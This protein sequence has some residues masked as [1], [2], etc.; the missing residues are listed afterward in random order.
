[1]LTANEAL[2]ILEEN[3][4][5][6]VSVELS[7]IERKIRNAVKDEQYEVLIDTEY[8]TPVRRRKVLLT[9]GD[10]GYRKYHTSG[11]RWIIG[12]Y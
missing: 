8:M 4:S 3:G 2:N 11:Y 12:W 5:L 9:L 7:S 6:D 1:M 10:L